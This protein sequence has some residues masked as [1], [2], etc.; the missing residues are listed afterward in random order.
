LKR[1][2]GHVDDEKERAMLVINGLTFYSY[3][4]YHQIKNLH[5]LIEGLEIA[6]ADL[7]LVL[8]AKELKKFLESISEVGEIDKY[9]E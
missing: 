2:G 4:I 3:G 8:I 1:K 7:H 5:L 9:Y 6:Q